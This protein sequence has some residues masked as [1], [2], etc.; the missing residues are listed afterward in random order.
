MEAGGEIAELAAGLRARHALGRSEGL[1]RLFDYLA[2]CSA[3]GQR[4]KEF[5]V[6]AAVF[7]RGAAFDGSQDASVRVAVHRLRGKLDDF[8]AGPGRDDPVRLALPKGEYRM[9]AEARPQAVPPARTAPWRR[10]ALVAAGLLLALNLGIWTAF[11]LTHGADRSLERARAS[12]PWADLRRGEAPTLLVLGDYYIFG[13]IDEQAGINRLVRQYSINSAAD[14]DDWLMDNPKAMGKYRDLDL[15]YLPVGAAFALRSIVPV[16][17]HGAGRGETVRVVMA[18][19]LTPDML[20][21][22]NIVYLGY[23][24]GLGML[25]APV[26]A[27]SR[28]AV[29]E[30]YDE[31]VDGVTH[32]RYVSQQ[33]RPGPDDANRR[34]YGYVAAF[35]GP[36]GNRIVVIAGARDSGLQEA[37]NALA[38]PDALRAL[39]KA[40]RG[41]DSFEALY[42]AEGLGRASLG[43]RL[44]IAA[45]R[46]KV[47]PWT[48]QPNLSFPIG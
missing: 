20:K 48:A 8:Y 15:Y 41:A 7:G 13:E 45:P 18:S 26:F 4:P 30:T 39:R 16:V 40:A 43:G 1:N 17:S 23:L 33:G 12:A 32:R 2:Q 47:D 9:V 21:R 22:S 36:S 28:F 29:G 5:E 38:D 3:A 6:A 11:W 35:R 27:G 42:E 46:T 34:D 44:L 19:D 37:A 31:L 10:Y 24:S 14:L 25:R